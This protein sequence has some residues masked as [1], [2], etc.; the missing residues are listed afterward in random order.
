M[1]PKAV[2]QTKAAP[3]T[4]RAMELSEAIRCMPAHILTAANRSKFVAAKIQGP[5]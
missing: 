1:G 4:A 3:M 2:L 5:R